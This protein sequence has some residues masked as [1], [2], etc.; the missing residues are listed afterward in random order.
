MRKFGF[1]FFT[2][3]VLITAAPAQTVQGIIL[4]AASRR[5]LEFVTVRMCRA[6]DSTVV[7]GGVSDGQG[8]F[9]FSAPSPGLYLIRLTL[10]GYKER[11]LPPLSLDSASSSMDL[12]TIVLREKPVGLDE[13]VV[14]SEKVL[15][16][17]EIDRKVYNIKQDILAK[18]GSAS[19]VLQSIPSVE[20]DIDGNLTL[21]GSSGV[22]VLINGKTSP[23]M[24]KNQAGVLEQ[25]PASSIERI[26]V[27][28]NPSAKY[29]PDGTA[30]IINIVLKQDA[31]LGWSGDMALNA[32]NDDRY[33]GNVRLSYNPGDF[34]LFGT[35]GLRRDSRSWIRSGTQTGI[36]PGVYSYRQNSLASARPA[37]RMF[38]LGGEYQFDRFNSAGLSGSL[39]S[40]GLARTE[41]SHQA[42]QNIALVD[43][44]RFD[45]ISRD[46]E[47]EAE[48]TLSAFYQHKFDGERRGLRV[49]AE[50]SRAL[51]N[52]DSWYT[53]AYAVPAL[54][55]TWE[56][57]FAREDERKQEVSAEYETP[58]SGDLSLESGYSGEFINES[59]E[60][61][62]ELYDPLQ[63]AFVTDGRRSSRFVHEEARHALYA[64]V[65]QSMGRFGYS[66]GL[67]F[68]RDLGKSHL[69]PGG[70]VIPNSYTAFYPTLHLAYKTTDFDELQFNYSR[71]T[72]R[73]HTWDLNPFA[74][75]D[76]PRNVS[77]GNPY[78]RPEFTH[79]LELGY[80]MEYGWL[81][82]IPGIYY[83]STTN[84]M[85]RVTQMV[86]DTVMLTTMQ[87]LSSD[88][89]GGAELIVAASRNGLFSSNLSANI[90]YNEIDAENLGFSGRKSAVAWSG[91]LTFSFHPSAT[92]TLQ[93]NARYRAPHLTPQGNASAHS[94]VN[95]GARQELWGN[96]LSLVL[97]MSDLF[98][99]MKREYSL[100]TPEFLA[101]SVQQRDS[102]VI[103]L[104]ISYH[105]GSEREKNGENGLKY[106]EEE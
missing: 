14:T 85:T 57:M 19:E 79:S 38:T 82:V 88:R 103:Y 59:P 58:L 56:N 22:E 75:Y 90:Y 11:T 25:M 76:D 13:V 96:R 102:R 5:P 47:S 40:D 12:G 87:N 74:D 72:H 104:G 68:E 100:A 16:N 36:S 78:L 86:G 51:E 65:K 29:R 99:T 77:V 8:R 21:R 17:T 18:S 37:S 50:A 53:N 101:S 61:R 39:Y 42:T 81:S 10:L 30:G 83:R 55:W 45:R 69:E 3:L 15:L 43:T 26:E 23:L 52:E 70:S 27:I 80:K 67:R 91:A 106:D 105:F 33:N 44:S 95:V 7:G 28:T 34:N 62:A 2:S 66:A 6:G 24:Q 64:I 94:I 49:E 97:T 20:L 46:E 60:Q 63:R 71:R 73:P 89:S 35:A 92:T 41:N 31:G 93:V 54:A 48:Y 84:Q 98:K 4:D 1:V 9:T 32:G